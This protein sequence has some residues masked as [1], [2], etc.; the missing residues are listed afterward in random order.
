MSMKGVGSMSIGEQNSTGSAAVPFEL[1][2]AHG[3]VHRLEHYRGEWLLLM[4][5]RHLG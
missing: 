1:R 2:D 3:G 4:F 5:H